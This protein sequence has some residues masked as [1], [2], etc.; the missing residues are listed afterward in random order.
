MSYSD[1]SLST[2]VYSQASN[3]YPIRQS[4]NYQPFSEISSM[5]WLDPHKLHRCI[6]PGELCLTNIFLKVFSIYNSTID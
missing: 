6:P 4:K 1:I 3:G 2:V 5:D